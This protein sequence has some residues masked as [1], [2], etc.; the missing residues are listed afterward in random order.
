MAINTLVY[1]AVVVISCV[2][3]KLPSSVDLNSPENLTWEAL[4]L[5]CC[6][7][8][9]HRKHPEQKTTVKMGQTFVY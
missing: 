2:T 8:N 6:C 7:V 5:L 1:S 9:N 4:L 3:V